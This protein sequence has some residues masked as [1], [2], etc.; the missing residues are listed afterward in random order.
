[1]ATPGHLSDALRRLSCEV[2]CYDEAKAFYEGTVPEVINSQRLRELFGSTG[3]HFRVNYARTPVDALLERTLSQGISCSDTPSLDLLNRVWKANEMGLE[4]K[5]VHR[6]AYEYGDGY[7]IAWPDED[8]DGGVSLY[9]HDP[10][11]VRVFYDPSQPRRKSHAIH[12]WRERGNDDNGL[13]DGEWFRVN[14]YYTDRVEQWVSAQP[15]DS[16]NRFVYVADKDV[17]FVEYR[18]E[19]APDGIIDNPFG[20]I[21]VFHFRTA[22]QYGRPEHADAY[23]PQNMINKLLITMMASVDYAG[24]PQRYVTTDSALGGT[25]M[26]GGFNQDFPL[27]DDSIS[28]DHGL[29]RESTMDADPASTW[30]L[31]GSK[32]GV[33][34]FQAADTKNFLE[35][36]HSLIKQIASVT[37]TPINRFD[38]SGPTPSG[39]SFRMDEI[40]LNK[41]LSDRLAQFGVTWH[42]LFEF[43]LLVNELPT[44]SDAQITWAPPGVFTDKDS[45]ETAA[46]QLAAGVPAEVVYVERGYSLELAKQ[47]SEDRAQA[48]TPVPAA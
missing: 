14:L 4:A 17:E 38:R 13:D 19:D 23:G 45:W 8:I 37:D 22:R 3:R 5:D 46:L 16:K 47:W 10:Q 40:P 12:T 21:P 24:F 27:E 42:E 36:I 31:S 43:C 1:M 6:R 7:I 28:T 34:Q 11:T 9:A 41:K 18:T 29:D 2:P 15:V 20:V 32:V 26:G 48:S 35:P 25:P 39:E 44:Q 33:G 30:I